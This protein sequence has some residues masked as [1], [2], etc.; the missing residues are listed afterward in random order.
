ME[1]FLRLSC[2]T[3]TRQTLV[4]EWKTLA[5]DTTHTLFFRRFPLLHELS[6]FNF[7]NISLSLPI[8]SFVYL[9]SS[10]WLLSSS[11]SKT[12]D[13]AVDNTVAWLWF[14]ADPQKEENSRETF[15]FAGSCIF[16]YLLSVGVST[17]SPSI[18]KIIAI[19]FAMFLPVK[20]F[21]LYRFWLWVALKVH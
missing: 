6:Y 13:V 18:A 17:S 12:I 11:S 20:V 19:V 2:E 10:L 4:T 7:I 8:L 9:S 15:F 14:L 3:R 21:R 1:E 5:S 16:T